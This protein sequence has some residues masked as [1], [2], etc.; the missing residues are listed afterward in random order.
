MSRISKNIELPCGYVRNIRLFTWWFLTVTSIKTNCHS[1]FVG[2]TS[3]K[4]TSVDKYFLFIEETSETMVSDTC[5]SY[6]RKI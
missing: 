4:G 3:M 1:T 6:P 2:L 5:G